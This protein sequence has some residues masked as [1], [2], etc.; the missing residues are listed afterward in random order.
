MKDI[1]ESSPKM[2][3]LPCL[4]MER[5]AVNYYFLIGL[6]MQYIANL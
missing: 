4:F 5:K 2:K 6:K 3:T 1:K